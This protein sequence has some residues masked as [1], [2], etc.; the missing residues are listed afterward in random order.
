MSATYVATFAGEALAE[1]DDLNDLLDFVKDV[2]EH[3]VDVALWHDSPAG[4][5]ALLLVRSSGEVG[6]LRR[7]ALAR[8]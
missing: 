4:V 8:A 1:R 6:S 3:D 2:H 7:P 5:E